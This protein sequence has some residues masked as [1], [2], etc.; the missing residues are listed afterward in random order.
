MSCTEQ[1]L[2]TFD[3]AIKLFLFISQKDLMK[4]IF[5]WWIIDSIY[6]YNAQHYSRHL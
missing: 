6:L 5:I 4:E 1:L 3:Q 2:K